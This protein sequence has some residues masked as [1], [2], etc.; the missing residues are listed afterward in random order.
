MASKIEFKAFEIIRNNLKV[1]GIFETQLT[2]R[3]RKIPITSIQRVLVLSLM[4][5]AFSTNYWFLIAE[6]ESSS[7]MVA[8]FYVGSG[9]LSM[10]FV[11]SLLLWK[12]TETKY[13]LNAFEEK[14][15]NRKFDHFKR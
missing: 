9:F 8:S 15:Q 5:S 6:A 3:Y 2:S 13:F 10:F 7:E 12:H 14:V 1:I 4:I 11:Y